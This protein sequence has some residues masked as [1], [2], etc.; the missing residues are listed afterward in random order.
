MNKKNIQLGIAPIAWSND[1]LHELGA[2]ISFEQ[3]ISEM[4]EAGYDG[5]EVGHK[6]PRDPEILKKAL[7]KYNLRI[8]S[9]W[10]SSFFTTQPKEYTIPKFVEHMEFLKAMGCQVIVVAECG[11]AIHGD[12]SKPVFDAKPVLDSEGWKRLADGLNELGRIANQNGMKVV[13]HH[14][15]GTVVQ[16]REEID[17]LMQKTDPNLVYL[18]ADTGHLYFAGGDPVKLFED[19]MPRIKHIHLKDIRKP[20]LEKL[21]VQKWSFLKGVLEGVFTV[22]GDGAIDYRPIA[23]IIEKSNYEGW[24]IVEAEQDPAKANPLEYAK[25]ARKYIHDVFGI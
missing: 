3:C 20:V 9:Q 5:S 15:M 11:G 21:K 23:K 17:M 2:N 22:P 1:D 19:Y 18:L 13:Y 6:Y 4:A 8:A 16:T 10:F 25:K 14:H 12:L 7:A 24:F